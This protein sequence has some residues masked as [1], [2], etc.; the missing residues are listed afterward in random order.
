MKRIF[1]VFSLVIS[2]LYSCERKDEPIPEGAGKIVVLMYHRLVAGEATN[3]YERSVSDFK[4]DLTYFRENNIKTLSFN[5]LEECATKGE[6]PKGNAVVITFDDGDHSWYSLARPLLVEYNMKATFFLWTY[7]IGH[8]SFLT[9]SEIE[10]MSRYAQS[11]GERPFSFGSHTYSHQYLLQRKE[12]FSTNDEYIRFLDYELRESKNLI[13]KYVPEGICTLSLPFGD[14]AYNSEII[15]SAQRNGYKYIRTSEWA[16][17]SDSSV[18]LFAI[19]G[20]P[21]LD[22]TTQEF[23]GSYLGL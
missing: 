14:G 20:L 13:D 7:M 21:I 1:I 5:E 9:W 2:F 17:I 16:A 10:T 12:D 15:S 11:N 18:N 6:M 19:P 3:L 4:A 22:T 8:D 23:I